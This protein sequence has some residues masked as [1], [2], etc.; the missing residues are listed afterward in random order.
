MTTTVSSE[1]DKIKKDLLRA[2]F[3]N[4]I[5]FLINE[6][7]DKNEERIKQLKEVIT[8]VTKDK[9]IKV[10][11]VKTMQDTFKDIEKYVYMQ[12]W[13]KLQNFHKITKIKEFVKKTYND[14]NV[15]KKIE[16][17][18]VD[19]V[20]EKLLNTAKTVIY[21]QKEGQIE[22]IPVLKQDDDDEFYLK[23]VAKK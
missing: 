12:P 2:R 23:L 19:A 21:N 9:L 4:E 22:S 16:K 15:A 1:I 13:N 17:L 5:N 7:E 6:D 20:E 18:L 10:S 8:I 3:E 14:E 11:S